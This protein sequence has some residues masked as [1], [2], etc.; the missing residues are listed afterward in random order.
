MA[1][2]VDDTPNDNRDLAPAQLF[3][4][5]GRTALVTGASRGIGEMIAG[6]LL[7]GGARV[8]LCGRR[9][10]TLQGAAD[11]LAAIGP[12]EPIVA[13]LSNLA[14]VHGLASA[15][16]ER[17][18]GLDLLV[19]NAGTAWGAGLDD[20]PE[21]GWD[22]VFD[23]NLKGPF[24]LTQ[25]LLGS[26]RAAASPSSPSRVVMIGSIDGI[27]A[28]RTPSYGYA[29]S[30]AGLHHLTRHLAKELARD[31]I[32]VNAI[33]PG[34]FPSRMTRFVVDDEQLRGAL[35]ASIPLGRLGHPADIAGAVA[36]L[37][38]R[39]G[40]YVTGTIVTVDGGRTG[41]GRS[42]VQALV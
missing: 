11:R 25:A 19:N 39:A 2:M 41:A 26:L 16:W 14:G 8:L 28:P 21:H 23:L 35:E 18:V 30:K 6:G 9:R 22:R 1:F 15:V 40:S 10:D 34:L 12:C 4:L 13:D 42:D 3:S 37:A 5:A 31:H 7:A 38:S 33:A 36:F 27:D 29:A 17:T 32:T 24:F 20:H